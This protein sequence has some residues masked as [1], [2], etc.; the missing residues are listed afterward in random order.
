MSVATAA[1]A[2]VATIGKHIQA[3]PNGTSE[4]GQCL[5]TGHVHTTDS[6][7]RVLGLTL[8]NPVPYRMS[9]ACMAVCLPNQYNAVGISRAQNDPLHRA[10][11]IPCWPVFV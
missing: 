6:G 10:Q 2:A 1:E 5:A 4:H 11:E 3:N 7:F 8:T 9:C